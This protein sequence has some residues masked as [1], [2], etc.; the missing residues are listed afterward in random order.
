MSGPG[1]V[2]EIV[3][4]RYKKKKKENKT[5]SKQIEGIKKDESGTRMRENSKQ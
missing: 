5:Q 2:T 3:F 1:L 4:W